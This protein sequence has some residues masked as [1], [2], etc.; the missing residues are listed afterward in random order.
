[1]LVDAEPPSSSSS[2]RNTSP[3]HHEPR[4]AGADLGQFHSRLA[5]GDERQQVM[6]Q[7]RT[8]LEVLLTQ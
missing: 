6:T 7:P 8:A 4:P 2:S 1:M 3:T 5:T